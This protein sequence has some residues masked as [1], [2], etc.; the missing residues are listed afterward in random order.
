MY[1][2]N[3]KTI[4][5]SNHKRIAALF[6]AVI[7][8]AMTMMAL[9]I[10]SSGLS[11]L[12]N[13]FFCQLSA[14]LL[15][16]ITL[17]TIW[18]SHCYL[19]SSFQ[20]LGGLLFMILNFF[21]MFFVT[22]LPIFT[23]ELTKYPDSHF[24][25]LAYI[26]IFLI[27]N[28][29]M[30]ICFVCAKSKETEERLKMI[31]S[32]KLIISTKQQNNEFL[33][34]EKIAIL[35][36]LMNAEKYID[37]PNVSNSLWQELLLSLPAPLQQQFE[38]QQIDRKESYIKSICFLFIMVLGEI[39]SAILLSKNTL[40]CCLSIFITFCIILICNYTIN[41]YFNHKKG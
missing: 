28:I 31:H 37:N 36:R 11:A 17:A 6:D 16:F 8:I 33:S 18:G 5:E 32:I 23:K 21:L 27:L 19:Y 7:A 26:A 10:S 4:T 13:S 25:L 9:E 1:S 24:H 3:E 14:Y 2:K 35:N 41:Y 29:V 30:M 15:S 20:T 39:I 12:T 34:E 22:L 38:A 40:W